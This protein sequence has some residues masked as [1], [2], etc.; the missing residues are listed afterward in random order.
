MISNPHGGNQSVQAVEMDEALVITVS[1]N[2]SLM[3]FHRSIRQ[4][5]D[6][7]GQ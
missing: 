3:V 2:C 4:E 1:S 7:N 6:R 5:S